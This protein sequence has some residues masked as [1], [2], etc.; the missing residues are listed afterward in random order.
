MDPKLAFAWNNRGTE[1]EAQG[2]SMKALA[3]YQRS[4]Q[5][6]DE[7]GKQNYTRLTQPPR[8]QGGSGA[9]FHCSPNH[10]WSPYGH[11]ASGPPVFCH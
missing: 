5:L 6:G 2:Q 4:S 11:A 10:S 3:D 8:Q 9:G 1:E 7:V